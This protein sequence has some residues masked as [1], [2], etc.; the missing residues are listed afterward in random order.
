MEIIT[1][2]PE[3]L[4]EELIDV[5]YRQDFM[6]NYNRSTIDDNDF[7]PNSDTVDSP[8]MCHPIYNLKGG[9]LSKYSE[10]IMK[11]L[12]S[13]FYDFTLVRCQ[14]NLIVNQR[15]DPNKYLI[16][17]ID[18]V[19]PGIKTLLYY[20]NDSDGDT[21]VFNEKYDPENPVIDTVTIANRYSPKKGTAILFDSN[22]Y[23]AG[24]NPV[25]HQDRIAI[26]FIFKPI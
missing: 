18:S 2:F 9:Y 25:L 14:A 7:V 22:L 19:H 13:Q 1:K 23:H 16:P 12:E 5:F 15:T 10:S 4:A 3:G 6:W 11:V 17:H 26:N 8:F 20:V 24:S 21:F